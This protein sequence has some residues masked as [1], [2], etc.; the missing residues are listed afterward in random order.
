[1]PDFEILHLQNHASE[2]IFCDHASDIQYESGY[3]AVYL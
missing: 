2:I 1:M 3:V